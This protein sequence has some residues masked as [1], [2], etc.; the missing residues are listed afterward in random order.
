MALRSAPAQKVPPAP[1][2]TA[3]AASSSASKARNASASACA[4]GPST[5]LRASGRSRTTVVTGPWRSTRTMGRT[6]SARHARRPR[7]DG[8]WSQASP[9]IG[10]AV[11]SPGPM[12]YWLLAVPAH[13]GSTAIVLTM[14]LVSVACF[15]GIVVLVHRRGGRLAGARRRGRPCVDLPLPAGGGAVRGLELLGGD[16]PFALLLAVAWS[17]GCGDCRLLPLLVGAGQFRRPVPPDV[18]DPCG[19]RGRRR[20]R[21]SRRS[22]VAALLGDRPLVGGWSPRPGLL[23]AVRP[24]RIVRSAAASSRVRWVGVAAAAVVA[25][26]VSLRPADDAGRNPPGSTNFAALRAVSGA[27]GAAVAGR[28]DVLV[29]HAGSWSSTF[30]AAL[31]YG[32]R[33][34]GARVQ[35]GR[36]YLATQLGPRYAAEQRPYATAL[37]RRRAEVCAR[38]P[39]TGSWCG[40][41]R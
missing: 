1:W 17:V 36:A 33:R 23:A 25:L 18:R 2:R 11:Y 22:V 26:A 34:T 29:L 5:A 30:E 20:R 27:A 19:R 31:V 9:L 40:A 21:R 28:R 24:R 4:V 32:L 39:A 6:L 15:A 13:V 12:L 14:G 7:R 38:S 16:A 10:E 35:V 41:R 37:V 8:Q 3:T